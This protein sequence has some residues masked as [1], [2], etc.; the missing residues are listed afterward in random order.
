MDT[1]FLARPDQLAYMDDLTHPRE[2][3]VCLDCQEFHADIR[4]QIWAA[5]MDLLYEEGR[6][7]EMFI[8]SFSDDGPAVWQLSDSLVLRLSR[9]DE[10]DINDLCRLLP[11][12]ELLE[13]AG[14][15]EDEVSDFLFPLAGLARNCLDEEDLKLYIHVR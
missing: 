7:E 1:L 9:L 8:D 5:L 3:F 13:D 14:I 2:A 10:E 6:T 4:A 11:E 12:Y 15:G